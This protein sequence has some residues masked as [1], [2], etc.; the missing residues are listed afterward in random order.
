MEIRYIRH[1][2]IDKGKWDLSITSAFN[3][4]AYAYSWYLDIMSPGWDALIS[5]DYEVIMPLSA[6]KKYGI[7]YVLQPLFVQ[8]L[9]VFSFKKP[10]SMMVN[11]F[12]NSIPARFRYVEI[13][14][15]VINK[16]EEEG[17]TLIRNINYILDLIEPYEKIRNKYSDNTK[18]NVDKAKKQGLTIG[19]GIDAAGI[20]HLFRETAGKPLKI[21]REI[22]YKRIEQLISFC[23]FNDYGQILACYTK[24]GVLCAA[25]F[26]ITTH[27]HSIYILPCSTDTGKDKSAM[28][29]IIDHYI[30]TNSEKNLVL[31]FEGSNIEGIARFFSGFGASPYVY[32]TVKMNRL[33][34]LLKMFIR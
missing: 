34:F 8:Q 4:L 14:L 28:F 9:G 30:K 32:L 6:G 16:S 21:L 12:I 17:F 25:A 26:I 11:N 15:N 29:L 23:I 20:V 31:D 27:Q 18:R 22:H 10:D 1:N 7:N 3:G 5:G 13:N 19:N 24:E 33:P 2:D